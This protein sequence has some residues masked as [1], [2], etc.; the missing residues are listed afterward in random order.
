MPKKK[1]TRGGWNKKYT[2][3]Q[4]K[5]AKEAYISKWKKAHLR[6]YQFQMNIDTDKDVIEFLDG[7]PNKSAYIKELIRA[8]MKK[9]V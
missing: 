3:K 7:V 5:E 8:D 2:E 6:H 4:A 1:E 9:G